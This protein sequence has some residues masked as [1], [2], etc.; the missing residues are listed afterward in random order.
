MGPEIIVISGFRNNRGQK[1][2]DLVISEPRNNSSSNL[3][4]LGL[5]DFWILPCTKYHMSPL[6]I[7]YLEWYLSAVHVTHH[8]QQRITNTPMTAYCACCVRDRASSSHKR[9]SSCTTTIET[10]T[11]TPHQHHSSS[12]AEET[13]AEAVVTYG[14]R[15]QVYVPDFKNK[16]K[17]QNKTY[18]FKIKPL[19]KNQK[20]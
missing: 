16:G 2:A 9:D 3:S 17:R 7:L 19:S 18:Q 20:P 11:G 14:R 1:S 13:A 5:L 6:L 4:E 15:R 10:T 8:P 12:A